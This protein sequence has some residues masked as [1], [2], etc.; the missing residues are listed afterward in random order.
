M[1][2]HFTLMTKF[3]PCGN[4]CTHLTSA[5]NTP[6]GFS[7][8]R[9]FLQHRASRDLSIQSPPPQPLSIFNL[10]TTLQVRSFHS[11]FVLYLFVVVPYAIIAKMPT[12]SPINQ[13]NGKPRKPGAVSGKGLADQAGRGKGA[14][15]MGLGKGMVSKR[16]R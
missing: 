4:R 8:R 16:H 6:C 15:G 11:A 1:I 9:V 13:S 14:K 12:Y 3:T 5:I 7:V 10:T 2:D